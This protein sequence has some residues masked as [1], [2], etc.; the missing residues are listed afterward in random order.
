MAYRGA[1]ERMMMQQ[2][3]MAMMMQQEKSDKYDQQQQQ[4]SMDTSEY[5]NKGSSKGASMQAANGA[6]GQTAQSGG[7]YGG[8]QM[9]KPQ[10]EEPQVS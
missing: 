7:G 1:G 5:G 8:K 4:Q 10:Y 9:A 3:P 6:Y 2:Q